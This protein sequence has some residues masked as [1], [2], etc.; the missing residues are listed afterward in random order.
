M[1]CPKI[2]LPL[3][4]TIFTLR[5]ASTT[6]CGPNE[7]GLGTSQLCN[8]LPTTPGGTDPGCGAESGTIFDSSC[9]GSI[10]ANA[11][12]TDGICSGGYVGTWRVYCENDTPIWAGDGLRTWAQCRRQTDRCEN[13]LLTAKLIRQIN[14]CCPAQN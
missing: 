10:R 13:V 2:V 3:F 7:I 12:L 9:G 1:L 11:P 8:P 5:L 4:L 14:W 6:P